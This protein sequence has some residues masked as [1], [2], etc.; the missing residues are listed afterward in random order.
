VRQRAEARAEEVVFTEEHAIASPTLVIGPQLQI[1]VECLL[2]LVCVTL[3]GYSEMTRTGNVEHPRSHH[4]V[5]SFS[6][7]QTKLSTGLRLIISD[8][9]RQ[10][11]VS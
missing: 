9:F 6:E 1:L 8:C 7:F 11:Q 3:A 4:C 2:G 10:Q 5:F